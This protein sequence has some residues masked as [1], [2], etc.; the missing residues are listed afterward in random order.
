[1][2]NKYK[3]GHTVHS[4]NRPKGRAATFSDFSTHTG[5]NLDGETVDLGLRV[6][7][8]ITTKASNSIGALLEVTTTSSSII[9]FTV[10]R[11]PIPKIEDPLVQDLL[12]ALAATAKK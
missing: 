8:R 7:S 4:I 3:G 2:P 10:R 11:E 6:D 1:M 5:K 9:P 12:R